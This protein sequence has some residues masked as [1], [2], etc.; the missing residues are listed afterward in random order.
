MKTVKIKY[1]DMWKNFCPEKDI[2]YEYLSKHPEKYKIEFSDDL[3]IFC[4]EYLGTKI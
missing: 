4:M 3:I 2:F 1:V